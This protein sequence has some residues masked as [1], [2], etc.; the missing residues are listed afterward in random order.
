MTLI[1]LSSVANNWTMN[2]LKRSIA[3]MKNKN[4]EGQYDKAIVKEEN[5]LRSFYDTALGRSTEAA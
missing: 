4:T 2:V 1:D 5:I 3:Y